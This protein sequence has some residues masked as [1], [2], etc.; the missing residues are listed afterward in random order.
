MDK[1]GLNVASFVWQLVAF[2]LLMFLLWKFLYQ[3]ILTM[4]EERRRRIEQGMKDAQM[5]AD[6][7][8]AA[9]A[10]FERQV[11]ESKKEGQ[12][13]LAQANEMSAKLREDILATAREESRQMI[14]KAKAEIQA[15]RKQAMADLERQVADLAITVSQ[16][17]IPASLDEAAQRR[18][19]SDFLSKTGGLK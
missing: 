1:I 4:L 3:P 15:E 13:I 16:T 2:G 6:K 19:I 12:V 10:E 18:L 14:E 11:A 8:A 9:Q 5:A 17:V 7:A